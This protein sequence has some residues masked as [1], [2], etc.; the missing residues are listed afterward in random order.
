M[1]YSSVNELQFHLKLYDFGRRR[2]AHLRK[3]NFLQ[4]SFSLSYGPIP[5]ASALLVERANLEAKGHLWTDTL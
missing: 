3:E 2:D 4:V 1:A 5:I